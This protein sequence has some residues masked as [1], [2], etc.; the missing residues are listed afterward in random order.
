MNI[1]VLL[2]G[3]IQPFKKRLD[4]KHNLLEKG[5]T[6]K[7]KLIKCTYV[8]LIFATLFLKVFFWS[9]LFLKGCFLVQPFLKVCI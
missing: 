8:L 6:K 3:F 1:K 5:W 4:Q 2:I 9:N 7:Y